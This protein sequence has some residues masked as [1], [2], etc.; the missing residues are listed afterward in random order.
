MMIG[1]PRGPI[2]LISL[3]TFS[4]SAAVRELTATSAP[5]C[6]IASAI[7]RP[8]PRPAPVTSARLPVRSIRGLFIRTSRQ[9]CYFAARLRG[10]RS[11]A[12]AVA[13]GR[14]V[15]DNPIVVKRRDL[16]VGHAQHVAQNGLVIFAQA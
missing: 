13:D 6:A 14:I 5:A 1:I 10:T 8:I 3:E 15:E 7:E 16:A 4:S 2:A 9:N 12:R 11:G